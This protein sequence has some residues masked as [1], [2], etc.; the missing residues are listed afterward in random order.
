MTV[1]NMSTEHGEETL[2]LRSANT[3]FT[4]AYLYPQALDI[5]KSITGQGEAFLETLRWI[6]NSRI[7]DKNGWLQFIT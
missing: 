5:N 6:C 3:H 1:G 4:Q 7:T 2:I